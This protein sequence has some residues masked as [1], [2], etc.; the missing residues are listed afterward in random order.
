[1]SDP[2]TTFLIGATGA[3]GAPTTRAL[4]AAGHPV[5][6]AVRNEARA[7]AVRALGADP[8]VV[9]IF[10][11]AAL[12]PAMAGADAVVNLATRIPSPARAAL[13]GAWK[14]NDRI[15]EQASTALVDAALEAGVGR[16]VQESVVF[17]YAD[18]EER[19]LDE[20]APVEL[21]SM[22]SST[23][24]AEDSVARFAATGAVGVALRFGLFYGVNSSHTDATI[25]A[26]R[27]G[28][29]PLLG[30]AD[31][32][33]PS[34]HL[35]D[36]ATSVLSALV[37]PSGTYN[38][39]DDE[40]MTKA[41]YGHA[42]AEALGVKDPKLVPQAVVKL[43]GKKVNPIARSQRVSNGRFK[44][45]SGWEPQHE[46]VFDGWPAVVAAIEG[47]GEVASDG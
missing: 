46:S 36:A 5:R 42:V 31:A 33:Q 2:K 17:M 18:G 38:I 20:D 39:T 24:V 43:M 26:V 14:E 6:A 41:G 16:F 7:Q 22:V 4:L 19:W 35:D 21:M 3:V 10:D 29:S 44:A 23:Q 32:F 37:V 13:P 12:V 30:R 47:S 1:M 34:I 9:D 28:L 40:P 45:A 8:V 11:T 25:A 15:R 27:K